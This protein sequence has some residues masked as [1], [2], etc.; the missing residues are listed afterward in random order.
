MNYIFALTDERSSDRRFSGGKGSSLFELTKQGCK[1]PRGFVL[2][3][4]ANQKFFDQNQLNDFI[5]QQFIDLDSKNEVQIKQ[6]ASVIRQAILVGTVPLEISEQIRKGIAELDSS[7]GFA[8]R[9]SAAVEDGKD[10][11][12]AGQFDSFLI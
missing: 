10:Y 1:V 4:A 12:W 2:T 9:S 7:E 3:A 8:V 11:S 5:K 6:A